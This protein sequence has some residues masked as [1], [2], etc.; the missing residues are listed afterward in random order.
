MSYKKIIFDSL[1][2]YPILSS[3]LLAGLLTLRFMFSSPLSFA[4]WRF[5]IPSVCSFISIMTQNLW[6]ICLYMLSFRS[7]CLFVCLFGVFFFFLAI[8]LPVSS[9]KNLGIGDIQIMVDMKFKNTSFI[10]HN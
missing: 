7:F 1:F 3:I 5:F 10:A 4:L 9:G 2:P 8:L 6:Q